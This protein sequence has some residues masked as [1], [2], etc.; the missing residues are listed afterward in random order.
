MTKKT[1]Y[2]AVRMNADL[3]RKIDR[4]SSRLNQS[5]SEAL[6]LL[7]EFALEKLG[8]DPLTLLDYGKANQQ[9]D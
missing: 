4:I 1:H 5:R 8:G 2:V 6:R 9:Q 3:H 7:S